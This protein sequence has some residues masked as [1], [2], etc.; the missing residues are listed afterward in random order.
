MKWFISALI[1]CF[2]ATASASTPKE[3]L[4]GSVLLGQGQCSLRKGVPVTKDQVKPTDTDVPCA[5]AAKGKVTFILII[6]DD[7]ELKSIFAVKN[8]S[9]KPVRIWKQQQGVSM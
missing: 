9:K 6:G 8:G 4:D 5:F 1:L 7:G 3:I 2:A